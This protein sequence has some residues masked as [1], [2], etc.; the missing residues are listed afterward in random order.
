[1]NT[2]K[3]KIMDSDCNNSVFVTETNELCVCLCEKT[4]KN[5][6]TLKGLQELYPTI[7]ISIRKEQLKG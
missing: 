1:M 6:I 4:C 7:S 2:N 3:P 5:H